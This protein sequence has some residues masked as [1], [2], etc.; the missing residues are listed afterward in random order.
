MAERYHRGTAISLSLGSSGHLYFKTQREYIDSHSA[1]L[2]K[3]TGALPDIISVD[4]W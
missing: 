3:S 4:S 2:G 1:S